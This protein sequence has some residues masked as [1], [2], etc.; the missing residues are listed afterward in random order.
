MKA[1]NGVQIGIQNNDVIFALKHIT[2]FSTATYKA[3]VRRTTISSIL[4]SN[5]IPR[6]MLVIVSSILI[7]IIA[8]NMNNITRV[9]ISFFEHKIIEIAFIATNANM[10]D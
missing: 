6:F 8:V 10:D 1:I 4:M 7:S 5:I 9:T 2:F 3:H